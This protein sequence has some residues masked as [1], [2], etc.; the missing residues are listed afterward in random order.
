MVIVMKKPILSILAFITA[1]ALCA[2]QK[3]TDEIAFAKDD[4]YPTSNNGAGRIDSEKYPLSLTE[5]PI[6]DNVAFVE[7]E[8]VGEA[9]SYD[10]LD[11]W[12]LIY[13]TVN[14]VK[15]E[16]IGI[17]TPEE[18]VKI[19]G[20]D[21]FKDAT[22]LYKA[23]ITYD[24]LNQKEVDIEVNVAKAGTSER[25]IEGAPLYMIGEVYVSP[26]KNL[27][28]Y[29]NSEIA[30]CVGMGELT[31]SVYEVNGVDFAYQINS[32][33]RIS[34]TQYDNLDVGLLAD[35][36]FVI[37]STKNNPVK[38][39]QKSLLADLTDFIRKDWTAK[40][41]N[42]LNLRAYDGFESGTVVPSDNS[43]EI[44]PRNIENGGN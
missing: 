19:S 15:Y 33:I 18:A 8:A 27:D 12:L 13:D 1:V 34:D 29:V 25:Q 40:G 9:A 36:E 14:F 6:Y 32:K 35:E 41:F 38:F 11:E 22:T 42:S 10:E 16:I 37:T 7:T 43:E 30:W 24:Y 26:L 2:C 23:R 31:F 28:K 39:T 4:T 17:Y 3:T 20:E 5:Q 21:F 44:K